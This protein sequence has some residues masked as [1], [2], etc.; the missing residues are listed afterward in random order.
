LGCSIQLRMKE[1]KPFHTD[2]GNLILDCQFTS[3]P[4]PAELDNELNSIIGVV[5]HGLFIGMA[6][7]V[8]IGRV[9]GEVIVKER[10]FL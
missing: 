9:T 4:S 5:E 8:L 6:S 7:L 1:N 2:N 10:G 3:I